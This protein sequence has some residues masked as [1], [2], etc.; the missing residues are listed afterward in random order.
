MI[1]IIIWLLLIIWIMSLVM[2]QI[3]LVLLIVAPAI[4]LLMWLANAVKENYVTPRLERI[5]DR[6]RV[7]QL[8]RWD[9]IDRQVERDQVRQQREKV[10]R[11]R[12][13]RIASKTLRPKPNNDWMDAMT[14]GYIRQ[15]KSF[16]NIGDFDKE[17]TAYIYAIEALMQDNGL[18]DQFY[19]FINSFNNPCQSPPLAIC[20]NERVNEQYRQLLNGAKSAIMKRNQQHRTRISKIS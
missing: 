8:A 9:E 2:P 11:R 13:V 14:L 12:R 3:W 7:R 5:A 19:S 16:A 4:L 6:R 18:E 17:R 20:N 10:E 15:A 1:G